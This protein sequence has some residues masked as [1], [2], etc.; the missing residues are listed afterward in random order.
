MVTVGDERLKTKGDQSTTGSKTTKTTQPSEVKERHVGRTQEKR[1]AAVKVW[2]CV[3]TAK[4]CGGSQMRQVAR[5][6]EELLWWLVGSTRP[7]S[8]SHS[9]GG[10]ATYKEDDAQRDMVWCGWTR[11]PDSA[12]K[13]KCGAHRIHGRHS[14]TAR[15]D[16]MDC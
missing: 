12:D 13:W 15:S 3:G 5:P 11:R 1:E 16:D 6:D 2:W 10:A 9:S 4:W 7:S 14:T 8:V